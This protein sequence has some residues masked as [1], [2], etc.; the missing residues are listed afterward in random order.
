MKVMRRDV[1]FGL[2]LIIMATLICFSIFTV[3][4]Q[5]T[6]KNLSSNY[7]GKLNELDNVAQQLT[8]E[9]GKLN[10]TSYQLQVKEKRENELSDIYSDLRTEKEEVEADLKETQDALAAEKE[11]VIETQDELTATLNEL[12]L[13]KSDLQQAYEKISRLDDEINDLEDEIDTLCQCQ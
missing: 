5:N 9:K 7:Y 3:H 8:L 11:K 4:Y 1:N 13:T 2:L 12:T 6:F 10:Q